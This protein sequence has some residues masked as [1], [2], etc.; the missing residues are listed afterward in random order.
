[1]LIWNPA[2]NT[3]SEVADVVGV[4]VPTWSREGKDLLYVPNDGTWI[5]PVH[6]GRAVEIE[7]SS[8]SLATV[9]SHCPEQHLLQRPNWL[10]RSVRLVVPDTH[11]PRE[12]LTPRFAL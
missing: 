4:S 7:H 8:F 2:T 9:G 10:E 5:V 3:S 1:M 12:E 11:N 6:G